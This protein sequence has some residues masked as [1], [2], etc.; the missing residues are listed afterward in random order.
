MDA[1]LPP[2]TVLKI[3]RTSHGTSAEA[4]ALMLNLPQKE[5]EQLESGEAPLSWEQACILG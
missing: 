1:A 3:L 5:Y 2:T 4:L